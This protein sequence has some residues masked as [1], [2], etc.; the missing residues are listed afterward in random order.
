M[1]LMLEDEESRV[2]RFRAVLHGIEPDLELVLWRNAWTMIR[3]V[4]P[5]LL[6]A[7][8]ISLDHDFDPVEGNSSDP[9]PGWDVTKFL[10]ALPPV[11]PVI[12]HTSNG[13]RSTWMEG[14]FHLG[15]WDYYRVPPLGENWIELSWHREVRRLLKRRRK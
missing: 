1:L 15:G 14:E 13:P 7:R 5:R 3:E 8:I 12:I 2:Q 9:G 6:R 10:S 4:E 11:C